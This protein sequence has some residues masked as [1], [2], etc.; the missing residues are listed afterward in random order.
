[1][2]LPPLPPLFF[3]AGHSV[4][5]SLDQNRFFPAMSTKKGSFV[6]SEKGGKGRREK[7]VGGP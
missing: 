6:I 4:H 5:T 2:Q 7:I 3:L 1:M